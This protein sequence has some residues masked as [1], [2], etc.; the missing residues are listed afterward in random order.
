MSGYASSCKNRDKFIS[1]GF[2]IKSL[3]VFLLKVY[4]KPESNVEGGVSERVK[5]EPGRKEI[6]EQN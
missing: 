3:T 2:P 4:G 1:D 5:I 6:S